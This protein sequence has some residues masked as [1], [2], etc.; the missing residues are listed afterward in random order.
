MATSISKKRSF[1]THFVSQSPQETVSWGE[2]LGKRL[3]PSQ[4][5][6]LI[7][8]LGAGKTCLIKGIAKGLKVHS[9][10]EVHSPSFTLI[11]EYSGK[12]PIYHMDLYRLDSEDEFCELGYED[13]FYGDGV[14]LVE[15]AERIKS[16]LPKGT[17]KIKL[18][19]KGMQKREIR[20]TSLA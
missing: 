20:C 10:D 6:A 12:V 11:N 3:K 4:V 9:K 7:G 14:T 16:L 15:W 13:Y 2:A 17:I 1:Q 8:E 19:V 5:V 18:K